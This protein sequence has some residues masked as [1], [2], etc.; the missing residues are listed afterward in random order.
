MGQ[1]ANPKSVRIAVTRKWPSK[2]FS[3]KE[4]GKFLEADLIIE[5]TVK[6]QY[7]KGTIAEVRIERN[8]NQTLIKIYAARPGVVIGRSGKGT[9]DL[10]ELINSKIEGLK[11]K[12][13]VFEA[14]NANSIAYVIAETVAFQIEKRL[15]YRKSV[16]MAIEKAKE[17]GV[18]GVKIRVS[19][20]LNNVDIARSELYSWGSVPTQTLKADVDMADVEAKTATAGTIGVKVYTYHK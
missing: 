4:Y 8:R 19:G 3:D 9:E 17:A 2:W 13:E 5:D 15:N 10:V 20:R 16:K 7:P 18:A 11:A 12:V 1:K 6:N 14:K